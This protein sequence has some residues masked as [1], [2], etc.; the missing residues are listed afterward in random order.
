VESIIITFTKNE[1]EKFTSLNDF[2]LWQLKVCVLLIQQILL[3]AL[4]EGESKLDTSMT[5]KE[6]KMLLEKAHRY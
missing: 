3:K 5:E 1:V 2:G 6:N 4:L